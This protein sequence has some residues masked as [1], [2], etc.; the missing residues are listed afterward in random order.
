MTEYCCRQRAVPSKA[1]LSNVHQA[2]LRHRLGLKAPRGHGWPTDPKEAAY[3]RLYQRGPRSISQ[4]CHGGNKTRGRAAGGWVVLIAVLLLLGFCTHGGG[5]PTIR[6]LY[7][8]G[9]LKVRLDRIDAPE[10][11]QPYGDRSKQALANMV[12]GRTVRCSELAEEAGSPSGSWIS[13]SVGRTRAVHATATRSLQRARESRQRLSADTWSCPSSSGPPPPRNSRS[14][15]PLAPAARQSGHS[16]LSLSP[17][18]SGHRTIT[19]DTSSVRRA[20]SLPA[21][22][23]YRSRQ[24]DRHRQIPWRPRGPVSRP[25][26]SG[27]ASPHRPASAIA[28]GWR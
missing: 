22:P 17:P 1:Y 9:E 14:A 7:R 28:S 16:I 18:P 6:V 19:A 3:N 4:R 12:F 23:R 10:L 26:K 8:G 11:K 25:G 20:G 15:E 2:S 24:P 5:V 13:F 27:T 21:P